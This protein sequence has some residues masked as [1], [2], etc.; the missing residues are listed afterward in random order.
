MLRALTFEDF[1]AAL[2]W[3]KDL[4]PK[5]LWVPLLHWLSRLGA[6]RA[7]VAL[8]SPQPTVRDD[9]PHAAIDQAP[10]PAQCWYT[11]FANHGSSHGDGSLVAIDHLAAFR[12][13][14]PTGAQALAPVLPQ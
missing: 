11:A 2:A 6:T 9:I 10:I 14:P 1:V 4:K 7:Q 3:E 5:L 13:A 8:A 12:A